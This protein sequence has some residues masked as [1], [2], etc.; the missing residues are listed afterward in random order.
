[1][2]LWSQKDAKVPRLKLIQIAHC[3]ILI[4]SKLRERDIYCPMISHIL[5]AG[6]FISSDK[7]L[8]KTEIEMSNYYDWNFVILTF[9]D[10]LEHFLAFGVLFE[11]DLVDVRSTI[12]EYG[13]QDENLGVS[14]TGVDGGFGGLG[15][16]F[17]GVGSVAGGSATVGSH[18]GLKGGLLD[19]EFQK[20]GHNLESSQEFNLA[21]SKVS[22]ASK[23]H[24]KSLVRIFTQPSP[25]K[26]QSN[27]ENTVSYLDE[28]LV[29][30]GDIEAQ[31]LLLSTSLA[32][33][34][35]KKGQISPM[36]SQKAPKNEILAKKLKKDYRNLLIKNIEKRAL[37][38]AQ[39]ASRRYMVNPRMQKELAYLIVVL[40]RSEN[41]LVEAD[42]PR[43]REF[44]GVEDID[45]GVFQQT[46]GQVAK[47]CPNNARNLDFDL[48][49][50]KYDKMGSLAPE[51]EETPLR[52][53][54]R[55]QES[56]PGTFQKIRINPKLTQ[57]QKTKNIENDQILSRRQNLSTEP[58]Q[59]TTQ[60]SFR[61]FNAQNAH[62]VRQSSSNFSGT[63]S[64]FQ[65]RH[66]ARKLVSSL[67][68]SRTD[69]LR[70][71]A[72]QTKPENG[73]EVSNSLKSFSKYFEKKPVP[74]FNIIN[75]SKV[76]IVREPSEGSVRVEG[77]KLGV[78]SASKQAKSGQISETKIG[79][80]LGFSGK[81]VGVGAVGR[82][83]LSRLNLSSG[84]NT[85]EMELS[86]SNPSNCQKPNFHTSRDSGAGKSLVEF[87]R[88]EP[89][90]GAIRS[91]L[92]KPLTQFLDPKSLKK[93]KIKFFKNDKIS[94]QN[95]PN[96]HKGYVRGSMEHQKVS[97]GAPEVAGLKSKLKKYFE[98]TKIFNDFQ[99]QKRQE[100]S[101]ESFNNT[102]SNLA[103]YQNLGISNLSLRFS[104]T[105]RNLK[106]AQNDKKRDSSTSSGNQA[107]IKKAS[108]RPLSISG[109]K[110]LRNLK[111]HSTTAR[112]K[113]TKK[114]TKKGSGGVYELKPSFSESA[115]TK[116]GFFSARNRP[117]EEYSLRA[118]QG[119]SSTKKAPDFKIAK[120]ISLVKRLGGSA[121]HRG[122]QKTSQKAKKGKN[123]ILEASIKYWSNRDSTGDKN[124]GNGGSR[125]ALFA[126]H[127]H[128]VSSRASVLS[129]VIRGE[130]SEMGKNRGLGKPNSSRARQEGK[131]RLESR[132]AG[133]QKPQKKAKNEEN[134][135]ME[136]LKK[137]K[138]EAKSGRQTE[139]SS[140]HGPKKS[141]FF[142]RQRKMFK[143]MF[144]NSLCSQKP[145]TKIL[146]KSKQKST[147]LRSIGSSKLLSDQNYLNLRSNAAKNRLSLLKG[148]RPNYHQKTVYESV[149]RHTT[150]ANHPSRPKPRPKPAYKASTSRDRF[151]E[152][153]LKSF[154]QSR[155]SSSRPPSQDSSAKPEPKE[156][157]LSSKRKILRKK[158]N[159][160]K[161]K[162]K[163]K[164]FKSRGQ[165]SKIGSQKQLERL[166][167][168]RWEAAATTNG[169]YSHRRRPEKPNKANFKDV[170]SWAE[171]SA[172][173]QKKRLQGVR[174]KEDGRAPPSPLLG[175]P[176]KLLNTHEG[177]FRQSTSIFDS[178]SPYIHS[179]ENLRG[180]DT[181]RG[182]R[183]NG[184][185]VRRSRN[186]EN[187]PRVT[188][189]EKS[190]SRSRIVHNGGSGGQDASGYVSGQ[191]TG[192]RKA[193]NRTRKIFEQI[194]DSTKKGVPGPYSARLVSLGAPS[195]K[196]S[197]L[198]DISKRNYLSDRNTRF[199]DQASR[200][201]SG[202]TG[203]VYSALRKG[204]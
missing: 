128:R 11:D 61:A 176:R 33:T 41:F 82:L 139:R 79:K 188:G 110:K 182:L 199:R 9:Y 53:I 34:P 63:G 154:K 175:I 130:K 144:K 113:S 6:D 178:K 88:G 148:S 118:T 202:Q 65:T 72:A 172:L 161:I 155:N 12:L 103:G 114:S 40:A 120:N 157:S 143:K 31:N 194:L 86:N 77:A 185:L 196:K 22:E 101:R 39:Q 48:V 27:T 55:S 7:S 49:F 179:G 4:A 30:E 135:I 174:G 186:Y 80:N 83:N 26:P 187:S 171:Y 70:T 68:M 198:F 64:G 81:K 153:F 134:H 137:T 123:R 190:I 16:G 37:D 58:S 71:Q 102:I 112:E 131:K 89:G 84:N 151:K 160:K 14:G 140:Q 28:I 165:N 192:S 168:A 193:R 147:Q 38:L 111:R 90:R 13:V 85:R 149:E 50:R 197:A 108:S 125:G 17:G 189:H 167:G 67:A 69:G 75:I 141:S 21:A 191:R 104:Q 74:V 152:R 173:K 93:R 2:H 201:G 107:P 183:K 145:Q 204:L 200:Y 127:A 158:L 94:P 203:S 96:S 106:K 32:Q 91:P 44:Y 66:K 60:G 52:L 19:Y 124:G 42:S 24:Q 150:G 43:L 92:D 136:K 15:A 105:Y 126:S 23:G 78:R 5:A 46:L 156:I 1:M 116:D 87:V 47:E 20:S 59:T 35:L 25:I 119:Y 73:S 54:Q 142:D 29:N 146:D 170:G 117:K 18:S 3:C 109:N 162:V 181:S 98:K 195:G 51:I 122:G 166:Q 129:A 164:D 138:K 57:P 132:L 163:N 10:H 8:K 159:M 99:A 133:L 95:P 115:Q 62:S 180:F 100:S 56:L 121:T 97:K 184:N 36:K 169:F 45:E 76:E 177:G